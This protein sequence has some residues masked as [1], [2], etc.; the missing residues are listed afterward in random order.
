[1][2]ARYPR[3][4]TC[5]G[6]FRLSVRGVHRAVGVCPAVHAGRVVRLVLRRS[7]SEL[8]V[9]ADALMARAGIVLVLPL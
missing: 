9:R 6:D 7:R 3:G 8:R 1:M 4:M 5:A 2:L